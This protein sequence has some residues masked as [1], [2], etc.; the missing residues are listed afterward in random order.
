MLC[1]KMAGQSVKNFA[2]STTGLIN[3]YFENWIMKTSSNPIFFNTN[4]NLS[5]FRIL[6]LS[7]FS[8]YQLWNLGCQPIWAIQSFIQIKAQQAQNFKFK[9]TVL[10]KNENVHKSHDV[11]IRQDMRKFF[12]MIVNEE[13]KGTVH[14]F[15]IIQFL[16]WHEGVFLGTF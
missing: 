9:L 11:L 16:E 2:C 3:L 12:Q 1:C 14:Q 8:L 5:L 13:W 15:F 6:T 10:G 4:F 7:M